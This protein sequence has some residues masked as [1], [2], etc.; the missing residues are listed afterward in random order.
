MALHMTL[1]GAFVPWGQLHI[2][3]PAAFVLLG[4]LY[5]ILAVGPFGYLST[6]YHLEVSTCGDPVRHF[7][8]GSALW[9][10]VR[11]SVTAVGWCLGYCDMETDTQPTDTGITPQSMSNR[12]PP[13]TL[14]SLFSLTPCFLRDFLLWEASSRLILLLVPMLFEF[15]LGE[16]WW[17]IS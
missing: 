8:I 14:V 16:M 15:L 3:L 17:S 5:N 11:L 4:Q 7:V 1:P 10:V 13:V 9:Q 2:T 6:S 12:T